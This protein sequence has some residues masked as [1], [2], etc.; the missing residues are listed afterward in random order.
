MEHR[1]QEGGVEHTVRL[2]PSDGGFRAVV[3][4]R[5]HQVRVLRRQAGALELEVDGRRCR[6]ALAG[7]A[8][9]RFV[10]FAGNSYGL[11]ILGPSGRGRALQRSEHPLEAQMPGLVRAVRVAE[12]EQVERGQTLVILEAMKMEIRVTAPQPARVRRLHCKEGEQV[13]RGQILVDLDPA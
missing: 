6:F 10:A 12:G 1:F 8:S 3:D 9:R 4:G 13:E 5:E 11:E 2:D 7:D